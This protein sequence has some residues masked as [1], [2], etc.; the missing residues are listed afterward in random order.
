VIREQQIKEALAL[1]DPP[2]R[3]RG[4][5]Q[6]RIEHTLDR[7]DWRCRTAAGLKAASTKKGKAALRRY[8]NRLH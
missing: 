6:R 7:L 8:V 4:E 1:L 2:Q 3:E 5:W